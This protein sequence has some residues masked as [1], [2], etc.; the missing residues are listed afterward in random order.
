[1]APLCFLKFVVKRYTC[2]YYYYQL[3]CN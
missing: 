1:M 2:Y 3:I